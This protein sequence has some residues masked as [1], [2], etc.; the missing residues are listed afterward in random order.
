MTQVL[1]SKDVNGA[2]CDDLLNLDGVF[3]VIVVNNHADVVYEKAKDEY[4]SNEYLKVIP[5]LAMRLSIIRTATNVYKDPAGQF[6]S[7]L[8]E[9]DRTA[10][11]VIPKGKLTYGI[12]LLKENATPETIAISK[13]IIG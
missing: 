5:D 9:F 8:L 13:T 3:H 10:I 2:S 12:A 7:A 4:V 11:L 1:I 6:R